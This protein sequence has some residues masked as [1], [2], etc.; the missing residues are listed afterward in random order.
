MSC[1]DPDPEELAAQPVRLALQPAGVVRQGHEYFL[2]HLLGTDHGVM[3]KDLGE[4][5]RSMPKEAKW[6][7]EAPRRQARPAG[8]LDFRMS[9]RAV[10][11]DIVLPTATWYEKNDLNT[12]DMHPFI[13][14][15]QRR[16]TRP[17]KQ[18]RLGNLQVHRQ[19]V[20]EVAPEILGVETD[21]VA[22]PSCTTRP[23]KSRRLEVKDWKKGECDL[24]PGKTA[25]NFVPVERDYPNLYNALPRSGRLMDK[26][27]NGGK[28][29]AGTPSTR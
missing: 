4:E 29:I 26:L 16:W 25:P 8:T 17:M 5:G 13:H 1:E 21:I 7:D 15:L 18:V 23:A 27:G 6:H 22:C 12:S 2:K 14:P 10:Y 20:S 19:E 9:P 3:G 11:S 28:G 24:I